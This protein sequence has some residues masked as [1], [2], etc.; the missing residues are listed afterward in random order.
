MFPALTFARTRVCMSL[1]PTDAC[2]HHGVKPGNGKFKNYDIVFGNTAGGQFTGQP[3][4]AFVA[5]KRSKTAQML[6]QRLAGLQCPHNMC[7]PKLSPH[8][9]DLCCL[10]NVLGTFDRIAVISHETPI[11]LFSLPSMI[12]SPYALM[13]H[14]P[15]VLHC[16]DCG[17]PDAVI[18]LLCD[19]SNEP[20]FCGAEMKSRSLR[21]AR[22]LVEVQR[23]GTY[24]D[25]QTERCV[26]QTTADDE[27]EVYSYTI[28]IST[29]AR[30]AILLTMLPQWLACS[31]VSKVVVVWHDPERPIIPE[32]LA[33]QRRYARLKVEQQKTDSLSNRYLNGYRFAT[34]A[35]FSVD[36]DEW[37]SSKLMTTT[38]QHWREIGGDT[39]VGYNA[40]MVNYT[41]ASHRAYR[42]NGYQWDGVCKNKAK[43]KKWEPA[44]GTYNALFVTKGGF[45]HRRFYAEYFRLVQCR[46]SYNFVCLLKRRE[47]IKIACTCT[48]ILL[49]KIRTA[50]PLPPPTTP[51]T[52]FS[53][54]PFL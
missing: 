16:A 40:R 44:C 50:S 2:K 8:W 29:F 23:C 45:L 24:I 26:N 19:W 53:G 33:L 13:N 43:R 18:P 46:I 11:Q 47:S 14:Q 32:L 42:G 39:M 28:L 35:V 52:A 6:F 21:E 36:D 25:S 49:K 10:K 48:C 3:H 37:Y 51:L 22:Q 9:H 4:T 17:D 1:M 34:E 54:C 41:A 5:V 27:K 31:N 30:D 38:F 15:L 20:E 7:S 12:K